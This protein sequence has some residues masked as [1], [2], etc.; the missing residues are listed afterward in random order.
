[1][2]LLLRLQI[3]WFIAIIGNKR[4]VCKEIDE[5]CKKKV[6]LF[7]VKADTLVKVQNVMYDRGAEFISTAAR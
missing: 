6:L 1:M 3:M 7:S 5:K 2:N 4:E